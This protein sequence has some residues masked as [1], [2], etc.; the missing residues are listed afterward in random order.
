MADWNSCLVLGGARSGKS[1]YAEDQALQSGRALIYIATSQAFDTEM[2][3]RIA[4][5]RERRGVD[6]QLSEEP[7]ELIAAIKAHDEP[8]NLIL[9]D[10]LTL[11]LSNLMHAERDV[12]QEVQ[13]LA[14][15][16]PGLSSKT[17]FV[18]NEVGLGIVP[19]N[20]LAR[21]FRDHQGRLNQSIA[22]AVDRVDLIAA[23][24]PLTLKS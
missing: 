23:G 1:T 17:L 4:L 12:V 9:V 10:C 3:D 19:E 8:K 22:A 13:S 24:L 16:V 21:L 6:W 14:E 7:L 2:E 15:T 18:S 11:W 5:H 20:A